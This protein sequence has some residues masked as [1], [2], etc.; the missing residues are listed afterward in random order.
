MPTTLRLKLQEVHDYLKS[1][2][3]DLHVAR[4]EFDD[5]SYPE[6]KA[7][8]RSSSF[9]SPA[10]TPERGLHDAV[11]CNFAGRDCGG[12]PVWA[13]PRTPGARHWPGAA[14]P[15]SKDCVGY[16]AF[17]TNFRLIHGTT[18]GAPLQV[19]PWGDQETLAVLSRQLDVDVLITG[20]LAARR[21]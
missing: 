5:S 19:V 20:A 7:R 8:P 6:T 2:C 17:G 21:R 4:G 9:L 13:V 11:E 15:F 16:V 12:I 18:R 1:I 10:T 14:A 3:T